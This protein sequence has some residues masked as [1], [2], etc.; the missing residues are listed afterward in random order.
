MGKIIYIGV[1]SP[2]STN[3]WQANGFE[4]QNVEVIRYDYRKRLQD[5][6]DIIQRDMEIVSLCQKEQPDFILFAKCNHMSPLVIKACREVCKTVMW[7]MDDIH[8]VDQ[9]LIQKLSYCDYIFTACETCIEDFR[10]H[11]PNVFRLHG[12]YDPTI[13]KPINVPKVRDVAFIGDLRPRRKVFRDYV[14]F[15]VISGAY[16]IEH[17]IAVSGTKI[18]LNF[19]EGYG[20]SNRLFKIMAAGGFALTQSYKNIGLDF[21]EGIHLDVF[22]TIE[23]LRNKII[24]YLDNESKREAIAKRGMLKVKDFD[25]NNFAQTIL[26]E[27]V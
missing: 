21:Q 16:G 23:G 14:E 5:L 10:D 3:V 13:H 22:V 24:Y 27:V 20:V 6:G 25:N 11:T 7:Y 1:F 15:E 26:K 2:H 4:N 17:S 19:T 8:N 18:N 12:G 9:E